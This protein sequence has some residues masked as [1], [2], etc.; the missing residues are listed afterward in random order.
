MTVLL[1]ACKVY[2]EIGIAE[3]L[4]GYKL[5]HHRRALEEKINDKCLEMGLCKNNKPRYQELASQMTQ[6]IYALTEVEAERDNLF[7]YANAIMKIGRNYLL[8]NE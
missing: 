5:Q 6:E 2:A 1:D 7:K 8:L 4:G 3:S